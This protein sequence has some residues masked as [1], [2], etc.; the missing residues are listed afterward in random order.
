MRRIGRCC[1]AICGE[2][3]S[4]R[5]FAQLAPTK[6]A[7]EACGASHHWGRELRALGHEVALIP[8]QYVK[9]FVKRGKNDRNDSE[10]ISEA[11]ARP[12]MA[13]VAVKSAEQ[14]ANAM[15]L[16]V[17]EL[18]IP[19]RLKVDTRPFARSV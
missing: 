13:T 15:L 17:R 2:A 14:Q 4:L 19:T 11:A 7:M 6:V 12:G 1:G 18:L 3:R 16:S 10:A 9:P 8:P 5:F